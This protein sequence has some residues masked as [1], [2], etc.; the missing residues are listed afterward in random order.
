MSHCRLEYAGIGMHRSVIKATEQRFNR[1]WFRT[2]VYRAE[3]GELRVESYRQIG[4]YWRRERKTGALGQ[5][6][7][8]S[9]RML[10][11]EVEKEV[12]GVEMEA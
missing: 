12:D 11:E 2:E 1:D 5:V 4:A 9:R 8:M 10:M 6:M 7:A 3:S